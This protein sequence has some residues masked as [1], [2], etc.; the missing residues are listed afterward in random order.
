AH[1]QR[2]QPGLRRRHGEAAVLP[3]RCFHLRRHL[4][5]AAR[6]PQLHPRSG[7]R[8][9]IRVDGPAVDP[10]GGEVLGMH[11]GGEKEKEED[12]K[13]AD[14]DRCHGSSSGLATKVISRP[15]TGTPATTRGLA[16]TSGMLSHPTWA[17]IL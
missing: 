3:A 17:V 13:E 8:L 16:R 14:G 5:R 9:A 15:E 7:D 10:E 1:R 12:C 4:T 11:C 2:P 6:L